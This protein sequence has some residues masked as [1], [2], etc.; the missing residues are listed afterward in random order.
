M[1]VYVVAFTITLERCASFSHAI[2]FMVAGVQVFLSSLYLP[3]CL[4]LTS[5]FAFRHSPA[6]VS[7]NP[8]VPYAIMDQLAR[9]C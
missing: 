6:F 7:T 5:L 3:F 9:W 2:M 4:A 8:S 1:H